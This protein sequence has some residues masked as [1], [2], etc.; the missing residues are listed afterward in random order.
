MATPSR[1]GFAAPVTS[2]RERSKG[3]P[4]RTPPRASERALR[5]ALELNHSLAEA[6]FEL[7]RVLVILGLYSAAIAAAER[8][9]ELDP[10]VA[11]R[12]GYVAWAYW[13]ARRYDDA[14]RLAQEA[15]ALD[16]TAPT[17][18]QALGG[19]YVE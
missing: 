13:L 10:M 16:A 2:S 18:Y 8:A 6:Y 7:L 4:K 5:R 19:A 3:A 1:T 15:I 12:H 17:A 9:P 14:I 11:E